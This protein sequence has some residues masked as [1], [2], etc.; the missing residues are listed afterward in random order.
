VYKAKLRSEFGYRPW[1]EISAMG[2]QGCRLDTVI[3]LNRNAP[4]T[5]TFV[6]L[7]K[8]VHINE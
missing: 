5:M 4:T 1:T 3:L 8:Y 6:Q 2:G 7:L